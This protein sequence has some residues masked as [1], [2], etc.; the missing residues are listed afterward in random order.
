MTQTGLREIIKE[1]PRFRLDVVNECLWRHRPD[2]DDERIRL[3]PKAFA[4]LKFL[5]GHAGHL[6]TQ[7]KLLEALWPD[8]F[9]QPELIKGHI[10]DLRTFAAPSATIPRI[11]H[12]SRPFLGA[13][14]G[15]LLG[16]S[17]L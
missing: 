7:N 9:V 8:T 3:T 13:G 11:L 4:V 15:S 5:V 2:G 10:L 6:V 1:F 16:S 12:L 17:I 14:T